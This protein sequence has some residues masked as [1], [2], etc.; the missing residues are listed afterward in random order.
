MTDF[1][2]LHVAS[3]FSGH[4]GVTR[5]EHLAEAAHAMGASASAVTDR[6]GLYGAVKHIGACLELG[7]QPIV[8]VDLAILDS[9]SKPIGRATV[10]AHGRNRGVGWAALCRLVS[11]SH[12]YGK[13]RPIGLTIEELAQAVQRGDEETGYQAVA[14]VLLSP[15][16]PFGRLALGANRE[17]ALNALEQWRR[18]FVAHGSVAVEIT[19]LLTRPGT[20][21]STIQATRLLELADALGIP[22]VLT[23]SVRYLSPDDA[24][25]ADVLDAARHLEPLGM[26]QPQPNAQA[27]LKPAEAMEALALEICR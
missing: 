26:F 7:I 14:T 13:K 10:L 19:S 11:Q 5:P 22:A 2:H 17:S 4:Y 9:E 20:E 16:N 3:A 12:R 25:T 23:N 24:L 27:W 18:L 21:W 1:T 8:G 6:D 15:D